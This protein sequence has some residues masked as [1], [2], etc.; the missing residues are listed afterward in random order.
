MVALKVIRDTGFSLEPITND[1][2]LDWLKEYCPENVIVLPPTAST[3]LSPKITLG[4]VLVILEKA[5][6]PITITRFKLVSDKLLQKLKAPCSIYNKLFGKSI[7]FKLVFF[8]KT[9][10]F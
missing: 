3:G 10:I 4:L 9:K 8:I 6:A 1:V 5:L 7:C 2:I